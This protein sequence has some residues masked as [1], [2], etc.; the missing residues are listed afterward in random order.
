MEAYDNV[1]RL[2]E[3]YQNV[4]SK[5]ACQALPIMVC[6]S[7]QELAGLPVEN[8]HKHIQ[9]KDPD[10]LV[11]VNLKSLNQCELFVVGDDVAFAEETIA[12]SEFVHL[13]DKGDVKGETI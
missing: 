12:I 9:G 8:L 7:V 10:T 3:I 13:L 2:R 5:L 11:M 6:L 1:K 4:V